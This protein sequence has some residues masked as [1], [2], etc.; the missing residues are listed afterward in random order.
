MINFRIYIPIE[1][2]NQGKLQPFTNDLVEKFAK[3]MNG[4]EIR[5]LK[6]TI[7]LVQRNVENATLM[8]DIEKGRHRYELSREN[9]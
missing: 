3:I 2:G 6:Y 8:T 1:S 5:T 4:F 9:K 7:D